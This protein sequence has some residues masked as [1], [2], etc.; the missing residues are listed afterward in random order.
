MY[1]QPTPEQI[2]AFRR[3]AGD[4]PVVMLNLLRFRDTADYSGSPELAPA[5]PTSGASAYR[6]YEER[7]APLLSAFGGELVFAGHAAPPL[8]GPA[9]DDWDVVLLVRYPDADTFLRLTSDADYLAVV[10][11]RTAALADSRLIPI[12]QR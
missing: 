1:I 5:E 10:G 11:H 12:T 9:D 6:C 8:I 2:D 3:D 4:R 7:V